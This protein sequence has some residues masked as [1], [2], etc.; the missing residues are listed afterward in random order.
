MSSFSQS[1]LAAWLQMIVSRRRE[2]AGLYQE[3]ASKLPLQGA[4]RVLDVGTGT[5]LQLRAIQDLAP[6]TALYGL[7]LSKNAIR[8]AKKALKGLDMDLRAGN[9]ARTNYPDDYFDIVTCNASMSYWEEPVACFDE[10]HRILTPGSQAVLFEPHRDIDIDAA[11]DHIRENM[12]D[13]GPLRRWGAVQLNRYG[14]KRGNRLG[15]ELYSISELKDLVRSSRFGEDH[16]IKE[17]A[18]L[19]IPIFVCIRLWKGT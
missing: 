12:K 13:K 14:L 15:I 7:D 8:T 9:I 17:T 5:G 3:I 6:G 16:A 18:L 19:G 2:E 11:L 10:I 1:K 4:E